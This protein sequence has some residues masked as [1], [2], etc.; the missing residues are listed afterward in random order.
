MES[1]KSF[2]IKVLYLTIIIEILSLGWK[3]FMP[4]KWVSPT[5]WVMPLFFLGVTLVIHNFLAKTLNERFQNFLNRYLVVTTVKLLGLLAI[6]AL[7]V[8]QYPSDAINFVITL[9]FNYLA[10]TI[11]EARV[12]IL[13]GRK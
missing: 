2:N 11:F 6:M 8:Y 3:F 4:V 7:Y 10:Y 13:H 9:F 1:S 5:I 12:L